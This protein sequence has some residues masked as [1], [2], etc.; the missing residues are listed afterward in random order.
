M[1]IKLSPAEF[2]RVAAQLATR[3]NRVTNLI[4]RQA[5]R[6]AVQGSIV[7]TRRAIDPA[8]ITARLARVDAWQRERTRETIFE[9]AAW[10]PIHVKNRAN[11]GHG[12]SHWPITRERKRIRE[13]TAYSVV[14]CKLPLPVCVTLIRYGAGK[15]DEDGLLNSLKSVRDGVADAYG[16]K[17]HDPRIKFKYDQR[18]A[19]QHCHGVRVEFIRT[20]QRKGKS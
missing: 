8:A 9:P 17:D 15:M 12:K 20:S 18:P 5:I 1:P 14:D 6:A 7:K 4:V 16:I 11:G 13:L 2:R 19:P 3:P 10:L